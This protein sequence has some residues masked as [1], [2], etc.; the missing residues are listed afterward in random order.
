MHWGSYKFFD[1]GISCYQCPFIIHGFGIG[2]PQ[3]ISWWF[4]NVIFIDDILIFSHTTEEHCKHLRLVFQWLIEQHVYAKASKCLI[5]VQELEFLGQRVTTRGV[6]PIKGKLNAAHE[7]ESPT[8]VKYIRSFL[9]FV[10]YYRRFVPG[11]ASIV[12]PLTMLT[13]KEVLWHWGSL[14]HRA[15]IALKSALCA[16]PLLIYPNPSLLYTVVSDVAGGVLM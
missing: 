11:Y 1:D 12:A 15:F 8:N 13:K 14:Q 4:C 10:N 16:A 5:R 6:A 9:G 7:W 2:Y 3:K